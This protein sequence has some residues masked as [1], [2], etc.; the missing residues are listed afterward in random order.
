LTEEGFIIFL[1][2]V[3]TKEI[4]FYGNTPLFIKCFERS[5]NPESE[6]LLPGLSR[7]RI[8][9]PLNEDASIQFLVQSHKNHPQRDG[10]QDCHQCHSA[11][12]NHSHC[13]FWRCAGQIHIAGVDRTGIG[14]CIDESEGCCSFCWWTRHG[15]AD[16]VKG[17][18]ETRIHARDHEHHSKVP[19]SCM[20]R[21]SRQN[22]REHGEAKRNNDVEEALP[23][24]I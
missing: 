17:Y 6:T 18:H 20:G 13:I 4:Q 14:D 11:I 10:R 2:I 23:G 5:L 16:P 9:R 1:N 22:I 3:G 21:A 19:C 24:S 12:H 15:V 8:D 7:S